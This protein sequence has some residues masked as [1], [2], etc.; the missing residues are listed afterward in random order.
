MAN[1][2]AVGK[3]NEGPSLSDEDVWY[4]IRVDLIHDSCDR[5][6]PLI[7][8]NAILLGVDHHI[9]DRLPVS[10]RHFYT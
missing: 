10:I 3:L 1:G 8:V 7:V 5:V 6:R 2:I 9:A 4:E